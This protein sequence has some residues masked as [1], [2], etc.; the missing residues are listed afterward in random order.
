M[1]AKLNLYVDVYGSFA[2]G[3]WLKHCDIDL[4]LTPMNNTEMKT[5]EDYLD[6]IHRM[7]NSSGKCVRASILRTIKV[8]MIRV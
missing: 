6:E 8:P 1:A 7:L 2:T 4:L 5:V 3:L